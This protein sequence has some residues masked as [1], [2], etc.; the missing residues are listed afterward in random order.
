[1]DLCKNERKEDRQDTYMLITPKLLGN[2][3]TTQREFKKK[4]HHFEALPF[5][6]IIFQVLFSILN[7]HPFEFDS[8]K[9]IYNTLF[10]HP[11]QASGNLVNC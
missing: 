1:M 9:Q 8:I 6:A 10:L 2:V 4:T 5:T 11:N 3:L 7:L